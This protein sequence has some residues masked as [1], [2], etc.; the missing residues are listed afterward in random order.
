MIIWLVFAIIILAFVL[1]GILWIRGDF[2]PKPQPKIGNAEIQQF[3]NEVTEKIGWGPTQA[4]PGGTRNRCGLYTFPTT[5]SGGEIMLGMP[6]LDSD[7]LQSMTPTTKIP[8]CINPNQIV[9][10]QVQRTCVGNGDKDFRCLSDTGEEFMVGETIR[11]FEQCQ[12]K[13]CP[14]EFGLI[15]LD[16]SVSNG[17]LSADTRCVTLQSGTDI[18]SLAECD[19]TKP[20]QY[21]QI[22]RRNEM[23]KIEE[24]GDF[25]S[26][27]HTD[28]MKCVYPSMLISS[29]EGTGAVEAKIKVADCGTANSVVW[30]LIP[31]KEVIIAGQQ[32]VVPQQIGF[33]SKLFK[34]NTQ[35]LQEYLEDD[36]LAM[37]P[38][39][40]ESV[41]LEKPQLDNSIPIGMKATTQ[42]INYKLFDD[43]TSWPS[44][45]E[46]INIPF[47]TW[48]FI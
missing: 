32:S 6:T 37:F 29:T 1:I 4:V 45:S 46:N 43:F 30:L 22:E 25:A 13:E 26:I 14:G 15:A 9:A 31:P 21:F 19:P 44:T 16:Y 5:S 24:N 3:L 18:L 12:I 20:E 39:D 10:R 17:Q 38:V 7:T 48:S 23:D 8:R 2:T 41:I 28:S 33:T 47:N 34:I 42:I 40:G 11:F 27:I 36:G 35:T